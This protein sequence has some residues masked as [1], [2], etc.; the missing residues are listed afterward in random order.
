MKLTDRGT[1]VE[2][3][4]LPQLD[5][6][7]VPGFSRAKQPVQTRYTFLYRDIQVLAVRIRVLAIRSSLVTK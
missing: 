5:I 1:Y 4:R 3:I 2:R 6:H 7:V